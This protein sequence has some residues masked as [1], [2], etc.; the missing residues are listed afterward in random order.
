[1]HTRLRKSTNPYLHKDHVRLILVA[2]LLPW[3]SPQWLVL[4][5]NYTVWH[6]GLSRNPENEFARQFQDAH[7]YENF[8]CFKKKFLPLLDPVVFLGTFLLQA[9]VMFCKTDPF[10]LTL[11]PCSPD[12]LT[13]ANPDFKKNVSFWVKKVYNK[14]IWLT[15]H[16]Y[17]NLFS[18][19]VR[20]TTV[21]KVLENYYKNIFSSVPF[22]KFEL[23]NLPTYN[24]NENWLHRK[25]FLCMLLEFS[26]LLWERLWCNHLLVK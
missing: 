10:S 24:Y 4:Q 17:E 14:V 19:D 20:K 2:E 11:E 18:G 16:F 7:L 6:F 26:K 1:M 22:K 21:T 23:S 25:C 8:F 15:K 5:K 12:F 3:L 9:P 13:S